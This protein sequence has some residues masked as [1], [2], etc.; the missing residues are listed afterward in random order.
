M[1]LGARDQGGTILGTTEPGLGSNPRAFSLTVTLPDNVNAGATFA[2]YA[3]SSVTGQ[4]T[5]VQFPIFVGTPTRNTSGFTPTPV[6]TNVT[7]TTTCPRGAVGP[8]APAAPA[9]P[10]PPNA[11]SVPANTPAPQTGGGVVGNACPVLSVGNPGPGDTLNPGGLVISG[12]ATL[13]LASQGQGVS[14]VDLF[15]GERDQGGTFLGSAVPGSGPGGAGSW[16]T[17]VTIPDLGR[18]LDFA[19]YAI[20]ANGQ[21]TAITF[22]VW[23]GSLPTRVPGTAPTPTPIPT[24]M[25]TTSTCG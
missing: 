20:G 14:R 1:F 22:P 2:A 6:A 8:S 5:A 7:I 18:S 24:T 16:S 10:A 11:P 9:S 3:L 4:E 19:A 25:S 23:V 12:S 15:L 13:P 17:S 21:Q